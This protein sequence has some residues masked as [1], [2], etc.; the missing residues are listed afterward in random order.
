MQGALQTLER[1]GRYLLHLA[2]RKLWRAHA[3]ARAG[4]DA[5]PVVELHEAIATMLRQAARQ[6]L[7]AHA[8]LAP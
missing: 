7:V 4:V 1:T 8:S 2:C 3:R 5:H 6:W